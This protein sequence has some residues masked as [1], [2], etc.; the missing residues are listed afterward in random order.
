MKIVMKD[1]NLESFK[2]KDI[3]TWDEIISIIEDLEAE[4]ESLKEELNDL[5]QDLEN[6]YRKI[7]IAEQVGISD[8]DFI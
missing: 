1:Y 6:N 2:E 7:D 5:Q 3:Y 8:R 4:K